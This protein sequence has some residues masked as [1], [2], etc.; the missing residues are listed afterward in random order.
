[1]TK[2]VSIREL[3]EG[4]SV[5]EWFNSIKFPFK[6]IA[7]WFE[8]ITI[9]DTTFTNLKYGGIKGSVLGG[10]TLDV[11]ISHRT[12]IDKSF[13]F[14]K[15]QE[16]VVHSADSVFLD[17][18]QLSK[19]DTSDIDEAIRIALERKQQRQDEIIYGDF[20]D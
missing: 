6:N 14:V 10:T 17:E 7:S 18:K 1:M 8:D 19:I 12:R 11:Q 20:N 5:E 2:Q 13:F 16:V 9:R 15:Y 3:I 4:R